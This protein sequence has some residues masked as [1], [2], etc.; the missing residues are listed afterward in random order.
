MPFCTISDSKC[1]WCSCTA[2]TR[3][4]NLTVGGRVLAPSDVAQNGWP[5]GQVEGN[6][7]LRVTLHWTY[8][9]N[10][11]NVWLQSPKL[12]AAIEQ[13]SFYNGKVSC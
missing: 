11:L 2:E 13:R 8:F 9:A 10:Y 7:D 6:L 1:V 3:V 5:Q 12:W 4:Y